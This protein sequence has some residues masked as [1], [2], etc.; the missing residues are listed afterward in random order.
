MPSTRRVSFIRIL[1]DKINQNKA[2]I[3]SRAPSVADFKNFQY[4]VDRG[5]LA[6]F[7]FP[8]FW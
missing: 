3:L 2:S 4:T 8:T 5:D 6:D 7:Y 1:G